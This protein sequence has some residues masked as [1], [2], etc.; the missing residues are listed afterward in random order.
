MEFT[1]GNA[2]SANTALAAYLAETGL[3]Q[4]GLADAVN[5]VV[6]DLTGTP[7]RASD[8]W[9]RMLVDGSIRWPRH[10][11]RQALEIVLNAPINKL[12]FRCPGDGVS[13]DV[14]TQPGRIS[15]TRLSSADVVRLRA[16]LD[17]LVKSADNCGAAT[18]APQA[19]LHATVCQDMLRDSVVSERVERTTYILIGDYLAAAGWFAL[20][21][22]DLPSAQRHLD[23]G[24]RAAGIAR[25]G[26]LQA[27]VW[28]VIEK[29]ARLRGDYGQAL[30]VART[31]LASATARCEPR[32]R[33]TFHALTAMNLS[34]RGEAGQARRSLGRAFDA[35]DSVTAADQGGRWS[36]ANQGFV[37]AIGASVSLSLGRLQE[38]ERYGQQ[39]LEATRTGQTRNYAMRRLSLA[40]VY[41]EM[42]ELDAACAHA[43][44]VLA[45][46]QQLDSRHLVSRLK[47]MHK[48]FDIWHT[49]PV[50]RDWNAQYDQCVWQTRPTTP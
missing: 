31:G 3:T 15:K 33:G 40:R 50:V 43:S 32:V 2:G 5:A 44:S 4:A 48:L 22:G 49:A 25:D 39:A 1:E 7:G 47:R 35:L 21:S 36:F 45:L 42:R 8:R 37:A 27:Y 13:A 19:A 46:A 38:A 14:V 23:A 10:H 18:L 24:L 20:D 34:R 12:G 9:V 26:S 41:L 16:P 11:Y 28:S 30:A 6:E 29:H 17:R